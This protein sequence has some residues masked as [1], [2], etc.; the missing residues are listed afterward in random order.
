M[1][2]LLCFMIFSLV[3]LFSCSK[4]GL[5]FEN[6]DLNYKIPDLENV[7]VPV[8]MKG[9]MCMTYN[10]DVPLRHV[11]GTPVLNPEG[12]T[13]IPDLYL[14]GA[15]WLS[16]NLTHFGKLQEQS[17]MKSLSAY[18]DMEA[19]SKGRVVCVAV[20]EATIIAANGDAINVLTPV[21]IDV[22]DDPQ[23]SITG[24]FTVTGG[25]GKFENAT[26]CGVLDGDLLPCWN[27]DGTIV[28]PR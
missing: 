18:L 21:R 15:S 9:E 8:P 3:M 20:F 23:W 14:S 26:G 13:V 11:E 24:E 27:V 5:N 17:P 19:L 22:T 2:N 10:F 4:D 25:S 28:F 1:K 7:K 12:E 6:P 16:G